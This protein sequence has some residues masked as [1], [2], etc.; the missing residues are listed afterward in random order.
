KGDRNSIEKEKVKKEKR[1]EKLEVLINQY[2]EELER[3]NKI[4]SQPNNSSD[5]I[6]LTELQ[7]SIDE[8]KRCQGIYFNEW[9]QLMGELEVM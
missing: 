7:K 3:L 8:V 5:Y 4:I 2:D 9:E 6:V 1:I